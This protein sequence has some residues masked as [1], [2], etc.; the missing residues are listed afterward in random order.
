MPPLLS[1][2]PIPRPRPRPFLDEFAARAA[3]VLVLPMKKNVIC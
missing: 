3:P 1:T 2:H